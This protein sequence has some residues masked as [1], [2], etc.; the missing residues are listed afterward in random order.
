[1]SY[2]R[3]RVLQNFSE[4]P[5]GLSIVGPLAERH[6]RVWKLHEVAE[7]TA[8]RLFLRGWWSAKRSVR[9]RWNVEL[10]ALNPPR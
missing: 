10:A 7:A 4:F 2:L 9:Q 3:R 8:V 5:S 1:M 6:R